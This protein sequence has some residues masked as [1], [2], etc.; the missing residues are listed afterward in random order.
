[1][2]TPSLACLGMASVVPRKNK[3]GV[4]VSYQVR[5]R[6]GGAAGA[7]WQT[8][9]FED[10]RSAEVFKEA[11]D[12]AGQ[13]WPDGWAKGLGYVDDGAQ[14][15]ED[16]YRF[17]NFA[18]QVI[19]TRTGVSERY[20]QDCI[21]DLERYVFPT[22]GDCY[23]RSAEDFSRETVG[24]WVKELCRTWV[25][26]GSRRKLMSPKTVRGLHALLSM[27]LQA[28]VDHEPP[29]RDRN[30][31][32]LTRLPRTDDDGV[33]DDEGEDGDFLEPDEVAGIVECL[34]RRE[35]Q[36]L[37]RLA[38]GTG[39]RWG[40]LTALAVKHVRARSS[41]S[42]EIRV[43]RAWK[44]GA[45][46]E[47]FYLGP[48]KSRAGRR[49]VEISEALWGELSELTAG[50]GPDELVFHNGR[51][52]WLIYST[53]YDRWRE[54]VDEAK[55]RGLLPAWKFPK[56]HG[57]RH[58]HAAA[59][60]SAGVNLDLIKRRLGH[61]SITMTSDTYGHLQREAH[62][63]ALAAMDQALGFG[64]V[65]SAAEEVDEH[66][67][68]QDPGQCLYVAHLGSYRVAFWDVEHAEW[69]AERWA[70]DRGDAVRVERMTC[71]WWRRTAG[72][73]VGA[74]NGLK[75]VWAE[76]PSRVLV[77]EAGPVVY[78]DDGSE[79]MSEPAAAEPRSVW[80]WDFEEGYTDEPAMR[81][82]EWLPGAEALTE[83][84]AWGLDRTAVKAAFAAAR[85]DALRI[86]S[87]HPARSARRGRETAV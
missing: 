6:N 84:R 52:Q 78:K 29:L 54:A 59:L 37:V 42:Y 74:D 20:R 41:G 31:C 17:K 16:R 40:E 44:R 65:S 2:S 81:S 67:P 19:A 39:L 12:E 48:P 35:D 58:S 76:V 83:A 46:G 23:V 32:R 10:R 87:L 86:C 77:W 51:G 50:R 3:S 33:E 55:S 60:I 30:P 85:T 34:P 28:A 14:P 69:T 63:P 45:R 70:Q 25:W 18:L 75:A 36:I 13:R 43:A 9:R 7:P 80:R 73:A 27:V 49:T 38:Y 68:V 22:F 47:G 57:L 71:D 79:V 8:E 66:Q 56:V 72:G 4:I 62:G 53:F 82:A 21:R 24:A 11:V 64:P 5:W 61:E 15:A 1:M 26:R